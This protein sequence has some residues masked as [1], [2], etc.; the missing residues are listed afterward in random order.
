MENKKQ[1]IKITIEEGESKRVVELDTYILFGIDETNSVF[2][3]TCVKADTIMLCHLL[4]Q[5]YKAPFNYAELVINNK[6]DDFIDNY[7]ASKEEN[8]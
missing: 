8:Q 7:I 4:E 3:T 2:S 1:K 5:K 6:L